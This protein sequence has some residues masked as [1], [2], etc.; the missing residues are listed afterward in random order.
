MLAGGATQVMVVLH[1]AHAKTA[2]HLAVA[3]VILAGLSC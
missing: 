3:G 2:D 1:V